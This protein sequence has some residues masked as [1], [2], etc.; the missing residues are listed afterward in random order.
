MTFFSWAR[1][2]NFTFI[3]GI[4]L[5]TLQHAFLIP[6]HVCASSPFPN[7]CVF[8]CPLMDSHYCRMLYCGKLLTHIIN[9][10][11]SEL[12]A[13]LRFQCGATMNERINEMNTKATTWYDENYTCC[14]KTLNASIYALYIFKYIFIFIIKFIC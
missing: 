4:F 6:Q 14:E 7:L 13:Y 1:A 10:D 12:A 8:Y 2:S 5:E 11:D 9:C 3:L